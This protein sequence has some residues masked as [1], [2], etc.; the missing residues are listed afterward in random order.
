MSDGFNFTISGL[1]RERS[2]ATKWYRPRSL[3]VKPCAASCRRAPTR[4][5]PQFA[6]GRSAIPHGGGRLIGDVH[7]LKCMYVSTPFVLHHEKPRMGPPAVASL[8]TH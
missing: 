4:R 1:F 7:R 2:T 6:T 5:G 8:T 3:S